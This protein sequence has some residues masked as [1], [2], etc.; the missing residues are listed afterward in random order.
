M[1]INYIMI[2]GT[3]HTIKS[4]KILTQRT[5]DW[6]ASLSPEEK[7]KKIEKTIQSTK[8]K[9]GHFKSG[10]KH[11]NWKGGKFKHKLGYIFILKPEHPFANKCGYIREHR[12]VM[13]KHLNRYLMLGEIIHHKNGIRD[14]NRIENLELLS[15]NHPPAHSPTICPKCGHNF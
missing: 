8:G 1:L 13:E 4:R 2:K 9:K 14:D 6:W 3:H 5:K 12:L 11:F 7:K 10:K 15:T